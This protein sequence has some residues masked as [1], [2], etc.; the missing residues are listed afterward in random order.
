MQNLWIYNISDASINESRVQNLY[1]F[2]KEPDMLAIYPGSF[3]PITYGHIDIIKR[4]SRIYPELIVAVL[5]NSQKSY[6]FSL[7][8]R[9]ELIRAVVADQPQIRVE[10]FSGLLVDFAAQAGAD[11]IVRGLRAVSDFEY[12][13][14]I[15]LLNRQLLPE[16]E[17]VFLVA[18]GEFGYLSSSLVREVAMHRGQLH[19]F[20]PKPVE[21]A[22]QEKFRR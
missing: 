20:V 9:V 6:V 3:D 14:Q 7:E 10:S 13:M 11:I 21:L 12:E 4:A 16:L 19:T 2:I 22:L 1:I 15:S 5:N 8:E 18:T 17:T